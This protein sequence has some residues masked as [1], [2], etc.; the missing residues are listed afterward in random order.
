MYPLKGSF[1][2]IQDIIQVS[3]HFLKGGTWL[4]QGPRVVL[5]FQF[6]TLEPLS[7]QNSSVD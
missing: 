5:R 4:E 7:Q 3:F 2:V 6:P 1:V